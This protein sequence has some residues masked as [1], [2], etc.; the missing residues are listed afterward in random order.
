MFAVQCIHESMK[1]NDLLCT[2]SCAVASSVPTT[3]SNGSHLV[4][5]T[6]RF[7]T[8]HARAGSVSLLH[9]AAESI[10]LSNNS[11]DVVYSVYMFHEMPL[12]AQCVPLKVRSIPPR[13]THI[14]ISKK[15]IFL[16][17]MLPR[18]YITILYHAIFCTV[19]L[20]VSLILRMHAC[21]HGR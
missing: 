16:P 7:K 20:H 13:R 18:A 11:Q 19:S 9:C 8:P 12:P 6:T 1:N 14:L 5:C 21:M 17:C 4:C 2:A 10:R 3:N 15:Y